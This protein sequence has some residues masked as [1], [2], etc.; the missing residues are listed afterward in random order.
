[1]LSIRNALLLIV[2][3]V[4]TIAVIAQETPSD[5]RGLIGI[6]A[7]SGEQ[8]LQNR[9]F[10]FIKTSDGPNR[11]F[12]NYWNGSRNLCITVATVNG[13]YDSIV[14]SP[15]FD[16]NRNSNV[17][18]A[19]GP[20]SGLVTVYEDYDL[21]GR[22]QT[23]SDGR[24][25]NNRGTLGNL[26]N[27]RASSVD[28]PVGFSAR[29]CD[30]EGPSG[31]GSGMCQVFNPG[32]H[33]LPYTLDNRVS[34]VEVSQVLFGG[35][36]GNI[37]N[38]G[39]TPGLGQTG[40]TVWEDRNYRGTSQAF[41]PGRYSHNAG[42]FGRLR[43]DE[44]S[45]VVVST[46]FRIRLCENEGS[47]G[48][49]GGRCEEYGAGRFNLRYNDDVSFIEVTRSSAPPIWG[50]SPGVSILPVNVSDL[51]GI[52]ASSGE[53]EMR[54]RGFRLV[55]T[56]SSGLTRYTIWWRAPSRQCIQVAT[57]N[58]RYDSVMDIQTHAKCY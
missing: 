36:G 43:N 56:L 50:G 49:G 9:G 7:S 15:P 11:R 42:Q 2:L 25:L 34:Y 17:G 55:D 41:G 44:A 21:Q 1:M 53:T 58:G 45:S 19:G 39:N 33:N 47:Y 40:A 38:S 5:L 52:R 29:L 32:R 46:G 24:Y 28:V 37:G 10:I 3:L 35:G 30:G 27:D 23:Y 20:S 14:T 13:R 57:A 16:C 51:V 31:M 18:N 54:N 8:E 4:V 22:S 12:T 48:Y 26:R 6:R